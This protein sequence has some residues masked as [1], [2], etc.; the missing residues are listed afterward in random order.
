MK[1]IIIALIGFALLASCDDF[2]VESPKTEIAVDQFFT[3][4]DD[5]RGVVNSVYRI[6]AGASFY[7]SGGFGGSNA[8]MG[9]YMSAFLI[10]KEK[11]SV[12][13]DSLHTICK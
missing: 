13:R 2:L 12:F 5:A 6:G 11:V 8:M 1:K 3:N 7:D 9:S 10:T 4:A